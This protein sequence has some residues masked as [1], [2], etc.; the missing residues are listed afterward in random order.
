MCQQY[1]LST[2]KSVETNLRRV[3]LKRP[4]VNFQYFAE[5]II[6]K[7]IVILVVLVILAGIAGVLVRSTS[8]GTVSELRER[9]VSHENA[10]DVRDEIR[11]SHELSAGAR[12]ELTGLNGTVK[13]ETSDS[14]KAEV[15]IERIASSQE[16]LDRRKVTIEADGSSL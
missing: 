13:I 6:M 7:R 16:A 3:S 12:V 14:T 2:R 1:S 8:G 15:F 4:S 11:Q 10:S 5:E 9:F